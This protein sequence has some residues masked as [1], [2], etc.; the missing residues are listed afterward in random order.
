MTGPHQ[1]RRGPWS[2]AEDHLLMT[3]VHTQGPLNWVRIANTLSTRTPKQCRERYHQNLKPTLCHEPITHEE[4]LLIEKLVHEIGKRWAEIAR[5]LVGRSDNAVKNWWNGSQN[6]RKRMDR[7]KAAHIGYDSELAYHGQGMNVPR[8][9]P[10]PAAPGRPLPPALAPISLHGHRS[11]IETPLTSP[12]CY[13]PD[14]DVAPSLMSDSYSP[15][16][17][18]PRSNN[19]G[20]PDLE[21]PPLKID[22]HAANKSLPSMDRQLPS[23]SALTSV[24]PAPSPETHKEELVRNHRFPPIHPCESQFSPKSHLP[25]AP[26]SPEAFPAQTLRPIY[27]IHARDDRH[28]RVAVANLLH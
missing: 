20:S 24:I 23:L 25:T 17:T 27:S 4:G 5:R 10:Y 7:R 14:S 11:F 19:C 8:S 9:L 22:T 12:S 2:Q 13:S 1:H 3:L 28:T 21:L 6:R 18:S 16:S 26:N 15:Y